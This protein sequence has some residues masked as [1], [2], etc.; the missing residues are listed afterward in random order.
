M[1]RHAARPGRQALRASEGSSRF[2]GACGRSLLDSGPVRPPP[3]GAAPVP[4]PLIFLSSSSSSLHQPLM[5]ES[6]EA[7]SHCASPGV[8]CAGVCKQ[9]GG[10]GRGQDRAIGW[11]GTDLLAAG[12]PTLTR[13]P[14]AHWK[15]PAAS[16]WPLA[17]TTRLPQSPSAG[18]TGALQVP[19]QENPG[20][21]LTSFSVTHRSLSLQLLQAEGSVSGGLLPAKPPDGK[22]AQKDP[23]AGFPPAPDTP[24]SP[25]LPC[26]ATLYH[27]L[28]PPPH[29]R[30]E[31]C[32]D[33]NTPHCP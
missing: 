8:M 26:Y 20:A 21:S 2:Q 4:A 3:A 9:V 10:R 28:Q 17:Q 32:R 29:G 23:E 33:S 30:P 25:R 11:S 15:H 14:R 13:P 24:P 22:E 6:W 7:R 31:H 19:G 27:P 16:L 5:C 12:R 1:E 18:R